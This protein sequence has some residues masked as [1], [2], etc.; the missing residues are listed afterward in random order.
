[1]EAEVPCG[2]QV[3]DDRFLENLVLILFG[4]LF[5]FA[6]AE[7]FHVM[8]AADE[9]LLHVLAVQAFVVG[10]DLVP[11]VGE[12]FQFGK[13]AAVG[14]VARDEH[15]VHVLLLEPLDGLLPCLD[16]VRD[17]DMD[18]RNDAEAEFRRLAVIAIGG[19]KFHAAKW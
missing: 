3:F 11:T 10:K 7:A 16:V 12:I 5:P 19:E 2:G 1:M 18:V 15:G 9:N 17:G 4:A 14:D 13:E 6:V 8:V